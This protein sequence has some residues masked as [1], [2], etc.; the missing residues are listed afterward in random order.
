MQFIDLA[1]TIGILNLPHPL[2]ASDEEFQR[3]FRGLLGSEEELSAPRK[4]NEHYQK[5]QN[6]PRQLQLSRAFD[7][8]SVDVCATAIL[9]REERYCNEDQY[10]HHDRH[11]VDE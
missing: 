8:G 10:G 11:N 3:V 5:R 2:L 4:H 9:V 6:G 7:L 1:S